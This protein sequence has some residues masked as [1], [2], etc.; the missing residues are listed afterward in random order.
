MHLKPRRSRCCGP[1]LTAACC[2]HCFY[3]C[4]FLIFMVVFPLWTKWLVTNPMPT[5]YWHEAFPS[6]PV[7]SAAGGQEL[8]FESGVKHPIEMS[9][10]PKDFACAFEEPDACNYSCSSWRGY[11]TNEMNFRVSLILNHSGLGKGFVHTVYPVLLASADFNDWWVVADRRQAWPSPFWRAQTDAAGHTYELKMDSDLYVLACLVW[12]PSSFAELESLDELDDSDVASYCQSAGGVCGWSCDSVLSPELLEGCTAKSTIE[13]TRTALEAMEMTSVA[14]RE[15][16]GADFQGE[17]ELKQCESNIKSKSCE[18]SMDSFRQWT[19][20]NCYWDPR[21]EDDMRR[22]QG[23]GGSEYYNEEVVPLVDP[24]S[25]HAM[26]L[27]Q[28]N[29]LEIDPGWCYGRQGPMYLVACAVNSTLYEGTFERF[30]PGQQAP[31]WLAAPPPFNDRCVAVGGRC[32]FACQGEQRPM[33]NCSEDG[34]IHQ[35]ALLGDVAYEKTLGCPGNQTTPVWLFCYV[36][37]VG[38]GVKAVMLCPGVFSPYP[39]FRRYDPEL[40]AMLRYIMVTDC[41][42]RYHVAFVDEG[43]RAEQKVMFMKLAAVIER[44]PN[45]AMAVE[46]NVSRFFQSW[47]EDTK[48]MDLAKVKDG[49]P[50]EVEPEVMLRM[51]GKNTLR[52]LRKEGGWG[53]M[54]PEVFEP[55]EV[56][57]NILE[58]DLKN[59]KKDRNSLALRLHYLARAKPMEDERTIKAQHVAPGTWYYKV[60]QNAENKDWLKL[61]ANAREMVYGLEDDDPFMNNVPLRTSRGKAG[62][63]NFA[64]NY[65]SIYADKPENMYGDERDNYPCLY[66][67]CDARHQFQTDFFHST[68]PYFF[69]DEMELNPYVGFTQCPQFFHEMQDKLDYLDNNNAQFFRLNCMIRNCCGGVSSCG[70]NGTWL[71]RHSQGD[72]VWERERRRE[73]KVG[74]VSSIVLYNLLCEIVLC[75][76]WHYFTYVSDTYESL[77]KNGLK[78]NPANQYEPQGKAKMLTSSSGQLEL[79]ITFTTLGWLQSAFWQCLFTTLWARGALPVYMNFWE[80]PLYSLLLLWLVAYWREIHF[81]CAHRGMHPWWDRDN[82][83]LSGDL[84]AFLYRHVHS[85]HHKSYNPGPWSGLS[86]HPVEHLLYYTCATLPPLLIAVHPLHFLYTKFHADIA[87]IGGHSGMEEP[88]GGADYHY[89]HHAKFECNYGVPFPVNFDKVFGTWADWDTFKETGELS[90]GAWSKQQMHDPDEKL[91]PLL[92]ND[93]VITMEELA[94]HCKPGDYFIALYGQVID[95]SNFISKH[96]GGEKIL[97]A[98][99]GK[100][101]TEKFESIHWADASRG[102]TP[103]Q[104]SRLFDALS[105][106]SS[107]PCHE[108]IWSIGGQKCQS[109]EYVERRTFHESCKVEDTASSLQTVLRGRRSQFINRRLSYGMAKNP[110]DYLAAVQRWAEGGV[111]MVWFTLIFFFGFLASLF[112]LVSKTDPQWEFVKWGYVEEDWY[113]EVMAPVVK[114][115]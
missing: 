36:L 66:S 86:M 54:P 4:Q 58:E 8:A 104:V 49:Y 50:G 95:I 48:K 13:M 34:Y 113:T 3:V 83:L 100:D 38:F 93:K 33:A 52:K 103:C 40:T 29:R 71:I 89:L 110:V 16:P 45:F 77:M 98:H 19:C 79:E 92:V 69:D 60:P 55:L 96:P 15:I 75:S 53:S 23:I 106:D 39:H 6:W 85:L 115:F 90:V 32:A 25:K 67:I 11:R 97:E 74:W 87:P 59:S 78:M 10:I 61:R 108:A 12:K 7:I 5:Q 21:T 22:L 102:R 88:M 109:E 91:A 20:H 57:L 41:R 28:Q 56:A 84:G 31:P 99:A 30:K 111:Y 64:E 14:G 105:P 82:G 94:K 35:S 18:T 24:A 76:F 1:P 80:Y 68:I 2:C 51:C 46:E 107:C 81:Y 26:K 112:R 47:V 9:P 72:L 63:L 43:H 70:T 37:L 73:W 44:V 65:L 17:V 114:M 62:G 101:V 27:T 42:C